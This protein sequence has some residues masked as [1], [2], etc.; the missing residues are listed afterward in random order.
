MFPADIASGTCNTRSLPYP[1]TTGTQHKLTHVCPLL[2]TDEAHIL[3]GQIPA[4]ARAWQCSRRGKRGSLYTGRG[5]RE[6]S[7]RL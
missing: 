2:L 1:H 7:L 4:A 6:V 3:Y 5:F